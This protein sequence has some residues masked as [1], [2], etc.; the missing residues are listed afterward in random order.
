MRSL[1]HRA[2]P[3]VA[4]GLCV[5]VAGLLTS[6]P[7]LAAAPE[8]PITASPATEIHN[9]SAT[10]EGI[11][12]PLVK[13]T[14]GWYFTYQEGNL[15]SGGPGALTTPAQYPAELQSQPV[16]AGVT[17]LR[18]STTYTFCLVT[19][20]EANEITIGNPVSFTTTATPPEKPLTAEPAAEIQ[21]TTARLTGT[22]NPLVGDVDSWY[23]EYNEGG[24]CTGG[25][26]TPVEG[27]AKVFDQTVSA[28]VAHLK[29]GTKYTFCLVTQNE[30]GTAPG[31]AV[32]FTTSAPAPTIAEESVLNVTSSAATLQAEIDPQGAETTYLFEYGTTAS[33]GSQIP[34]SPVS[35]GAS[36]GTPEG[37]EVRPEGLQPDTTYHFRVVAANAIGP[38]Y[39]P[40]ET[41]TTQ[42]AGTVFTLPDGRVWE[43][44]SPP[45]KLGGAVYTVNI[46]YGGELQASENGQTVAYLTST[47]ATSGGQSNPF[48]D[49]VL[50]RR[51]PEGWSSEDINTRHNYASGGVEEGG[52]LHFGALSEYHIFSPDLSRAWA[53]P[54]GTTP[55]GTVPPEH[56]RE[57]YIRD[58]DTGTFTPTRLNQYEWYEEQ[59]ALAQGATFT[60]ELSVG[61][62]GSGPGQFQSP[63]GVAVQQA[64]GDFFV[65]DTGNDRVQVFAPTGALL[66]A[67]TGAEVPGGSF[68]EVDAV[69]VD[70]TG[71]ASAG[72][73]YV[74]AYSKGVIDKFKPK[75]SEPKQGYEY[76][77]Q[78]VGKTGG[79]LKEGASELSQPSALA[80]DGHGNLYVGQ[81]KGPVEEF[82]ASGTFVATLGQAIPSTTSLA[83][84]FSGTALYVATEAGTLTKLSVEAVAHEV[85]GE[86]A[87]AGE[88]ATAVTVDQETGALFVDGGAS[89]IKEYEEAAT[90]KSGEAPLA[91]FAAGGEISHSSLGVAY[92][93]YNKT[94]T[95]YVTETGGQVLIFKLVAHKSCDPSTSP[96]GGTAVV[97]A[98][99]KDG[100][101]V[102]FNSGGKTGPLE[103]AR[104][105]GTEWTTTPVLKQ[106]A[107]TIPWTA[108]GPSPEFGLS[109]DGRYVAFMTNANP[110][111]YDNRDAVTGAPDEEVYLYDAA[112]NQLACASCNPTGARPLGIFDDGRGYIDK[113]LVDR[114]VDW[115]GATLAGSIPDWTEA[116]QL[117]PIY[118]PRFML[119]NGMLFFNSPDTLVPQA[120]NGQENVYEY[121]A[122][123][124]NGCEK[125]AGCVSLI[126]SGASKQESAFVDASASGNDVFFLT[127]S[128]LVTQDYDNNYDMY[129]AHLCNSEVPCIAPAPTSP[130]PCET[131]DS[132]K[133]PP[134]PQPGIFGPPPSA[135]FVGAGNAVQPPPTPEVAPHAQTK[136][137]KLAAALRVCKKKKKK[138]KRRSCEAQ[139]KRRYGATKSSR[140]TAVKSLSKTAKRDRIGG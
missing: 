84:N 5:L 6:A 89:G 16:A 77:C 80:I 10:L 49:Q 28:A 75:G 65:A 133:A 74:A 109:P 68:T 29:A 55:I 99:S 14:D 96:A 37:V 50:S 88:G 115:A 95:V 27:P 117:A 90:D 81:S 15:C 39:G 20:N 125:A 62:V 87:L 24:V 34:A 128:R 83:V 69:A 105:N 32:S 138:A 52:T 56:S 30:V 123:G 53:E 124:T 93:R 100:C 126:S 43:L 94:R 22:V 73:V 127:E 19:R 108:G 86:V 70:N 63:H 111:G 106:A 54:E 23:F 122:Q 91:E 67:I 139:A 31:N 76:V 12:N 137:Q 60:H 113:L 57:T 129:D 9:S 51:G 61:A 42:Q 64:T 120:V 7:A 66:T 33:Y 140:A 97:D 119:N 114:N 40:D 72:D 47:P 135:T 130:P 46:A 25:P 112:T 78:I 4:V 82:D 107:E 26:T 121:E 8:A 11:V 131:G 18:P 58:N 41:F 3:G 134:T 13:A 59:L 118:E 48:E 110:T 38:A 2:A 136:K 132:C 85:Q 1:V 104:Y 71:S 21:S 103:V 35:L 116:E 44:V 17:G 79:C 92:S 98:V 102:Y 45:N 36:G 101:S